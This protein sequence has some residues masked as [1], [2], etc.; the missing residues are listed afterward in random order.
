M[1]LIQTFP[2]GGGG[3]NIPNG[4]TVTPTDDISIWLKCAGLHQSYTTLNEVLADSAVLSALM[5]NTN[6][7]DYL[8][9]STTWTTDICANETAINCIGSNDYCADI[10]LA[11]STWNTAICNSVYWQEV[12]SPLVPTKSSSDQSGVS[13][14]AYYSASMMPYKAFDGDTT[15]MWAS[16]AKASTTS[17]AWIQYDFGQPVKV[18]KSKAMPEFTVGGGGDDLNGA[19]K[20]YIA[21]SNDNITF[22]PISE[23]VTTRNVLEW[24][25]V[26]FA[27]NEAYRYWRCQITETVGAVTSIAPSLREL[28]FYGRG[29]HPVV[30]TKADI[31]AIGTEEAGTTASRAYAVGEHFYKNGKFCT[32]KAAI[33]QGA[34]FTLGTNYVE[35]TIADELIIEDFLSHI[36]LNS[37]ITWN[38]N[39]TIIKKIGK[40]VYFTIRGQFPASVGNGYNMFTLDKD[41]IVGETYS[42]LFSSDWTSPQ[43]IGCIDCYSYNGSSICQVAGNPSLS[44]KSFVATGYFLTKY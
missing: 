25:E 4:S 31:S 12:L 24:S 38:M 44:N 42:I 18:Y 3:A 39:N 1:S 17:G 33:A 10:L 19:K 20:Y 28:Q 7:V 40:T 32:V 34:T 15:T 22:T 14:D 5:A 2:D 8:V 16:T 35:G 21:A 13:A 6:A 11:N 23:E 26:S 30:D 27:C 41:I 37:N 9:R 43:V 29:E 36:T